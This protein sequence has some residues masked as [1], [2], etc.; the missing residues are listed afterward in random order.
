MAHCLRKGEPVTAAST[1]LANAQEVLDCP[2]TAA[3]DARRQAGNTSESVEG[4]TAG[5]RRLAARLLRT[6]DEERRRIARELNDNLG[7][8]LVAAKIRLDVPACEERVGS[9]HLREARRLVGRVIRDTCM[10]SHLLHPPLLD[11]TGSLSTA[12]WYMEGFERRSGIT[13]T[14]AARA[15]PNRSRQR[16][17]PPCF[18]YCRRH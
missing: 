3:E 8:R 7:Q 14:L 6:Q 18:R 4:R 12:H 9:P 2:G 1:K 16:L 5:L 11:E 17:R 15:I 10:L 13:T